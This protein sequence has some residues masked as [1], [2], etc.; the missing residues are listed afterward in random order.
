M[1]TWPAQGACETCGRDHSTHDGRHTGDEL[2]V[3]L[4]RFDRMN[5]LLATIAEVLSPKRYRP[6][7]EALEDGTGRATIDFPVFP[8]GADLIWVVERT[9]VWTNSTGTPAVGIFVLDAVPKSTTFNPRDLVD[10]T[11]API[12]AGEQTQPFLAKGGEHVVAQW[13]G[14]SAGAL[15]RFR[16]QY[17]QTWQSPD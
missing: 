1:S 11:N 16:L 14:L 3:L 7:Q 13:S 2:S 9:F 10:W 15:C 17:R 8:G 12:A 6:V 5:V 4:E